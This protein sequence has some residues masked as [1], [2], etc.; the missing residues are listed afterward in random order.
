MVRDA[1]AARN[2]LV[3]ALIKVT[4][5][6][7]AKRV[8]DNEVAKLKKR[9][10]DN[11]KKRLDEQQKKVGS[12]EKALKR[13]FDRLLE[14]QQSRK[15]LFGIGREDLKVNDDLQDTWSDYFQAQ[16]AV[17][18]RSQEIVA[19]A[20]RLKRQLDRIEDIA[21]QK[22]QGTSNSKLMEI[23]KSPEVFA[24]MGNEKGAFSWDAPLTLA[25]I[26]P[27]KDALIPRPKSLAGDGSP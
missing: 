26:K 23:L 17:T 25:T 10:E 3:D 22:A 13:G 8:A 1:L 24:T 21:K 19:T 5:E 7:S 12:Q 2:E 9:W 27:N 14:L 4:D 16:D 20:K 18:S 6:D 15:D 11:I